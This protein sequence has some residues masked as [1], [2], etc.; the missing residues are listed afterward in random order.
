[1]ELYL[2][3][4]LL[5]GIP[6]FGLEA[7]MLGDGGRVSSLRRNRTELFKAMIIP[8]MAVV[9]SSVFVGFVLDLG[10]LYVCALIFPLI[11]FVGKIFSMI[12]K[13][14]VKSRLSPKKNET[15][16]EI[17]SMLKKRGFGSL[18]EDEEEDSSE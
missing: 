4:I 9:L 8:G 16:D 14:E 11:F 3:I 18:V 15:R 2:L 13:N 1:M 17:E 5:T 12:E 10:P 7:L 6:T